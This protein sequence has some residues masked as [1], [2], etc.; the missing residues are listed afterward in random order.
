MRSILTGATIVCRDVERSAAFYCMALGMKV[1][2]QSKAIV[3]LQD[4]RGFLLTLQ[5]APSE[6]YCSSG[7]SP[8]LSYLVDHFDSYDSRLLEYGA[9]RDGDVRED[10]DLKTA[11]YRAVD[12]N[13]ITVTQLK[14]AEEVR[15][16]FEATRS[17]AD[18]SSEPRDEKKEELKNLLRTLK[19]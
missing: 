3:E 10:E 15:S 19:L 4:K 9:I 17:I 5:K 12:G 7:Y 13:M 14:R 8:M 18:E 2:Y 1:E 6:A 11:C 16:L